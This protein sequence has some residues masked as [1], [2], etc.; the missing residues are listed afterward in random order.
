MQ[1][2]RPEAV[3]HAQALSDVD[4]CERAPDEAHRFNVQTVEHLCHALRH[5]PPVFMSISSDYVFD[6]R[7]SRAYTE[8]DEPRP[9]SVYGRSKFAGER[10]ALQ[11]PKTYIVRPSTLFGPAR[12]NFCQSIVEALRG[13]R[14]IQVF[15]NQTT[16]PTYTEDLA[17]ALERLLRV[18]MGAPSEPPRLYHITNAGACSR[19][20][21]ATFVADRLGADHRLLEPVTMA[22]RGLPAPRPANSSLASEHLV[23]IIGGNLRSWQDAV[24]TYLS[25]DDWRN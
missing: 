18:L 24:A 4:R 13:G 5:Q 22:A 12:R 23:R 19:L 7:Q 2:V 14:R 16:S 10:V 9:L 20:E 21:F 6:G 15:K 8:R 11:Y 1:V 17:E 3:I 25:T